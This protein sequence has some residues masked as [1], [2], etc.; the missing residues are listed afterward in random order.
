[1]WFV[2]IVLD[3]DGLSAEFWLIWTD[4]CFAT[5]ETKRAVVSRDFGDRYLE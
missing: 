3:C 1:M 5:L 2:S 4:E